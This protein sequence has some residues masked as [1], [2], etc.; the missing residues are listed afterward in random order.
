MASVAKPSLEWE[1]S[2]WAHGARFVAGV[3][4]VGRG[5]LAGPLVAA[6]V[7]LPECGKRG[8]PKL[9]GL[10]DSKLHTPKQR[11]EW[12]EIILEHAVA[13]GVGAV[14]S[15]ELDL[16]GVAAANRIAMERAV[17][18]LSQIPDALMLDAA[19]IESE[20]PQVGLI[21]GDALCLSIAAASV[22]AKVTRD[23]TMCALHE[24]EVNYGFAIHKGYGTAEHLD[25]LRKFGPCAAHRKCFAPVAALLDA[26]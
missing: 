3:D 19:V 18:G 7:I 17:E 26:S 6:A 15:D 5:A 25:A 23:R 20:L 14:E 8:H 10:T 12:F 2:W 22:I 21:D 24:V 13:I 4:E 1:R 16:L 11:D 9:R